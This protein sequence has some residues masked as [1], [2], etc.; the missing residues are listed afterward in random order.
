MASDF[1]KPDRVHTLFENEIRSKMWGLPTS[2]LFML[3]KKTVPV[4]YNMGIKTIGDLANSNMNIIIKRFGKFGKM[5]WEYANG[6]DE[7]PVNYIVEKSKSIGNSTT[8]PMDV[9]NLEKL[10]EVLFEL[11]EN[12]TYRLRKERLLAVTVSVQIRTNK[13]EDSSH[14][15]KLLSPTANTI[16]IYNKAKEL[17]NEFYKKGTY[18]R[19][20]GVRVDNLIDENEKQ[21]SFFDAQ[22]DIKHEKIDETLDKIK[23]K[24]GFTSVTRGRGINKQKD[25][26]LH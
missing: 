7:S 25:G 18:V 4:L 15:G 3:G 2:D 14:Q 8:L 17:L 9:T 13:F 1:E 22:K 16:D 11:T 6:I 5:M 26:T 21:I 10:Y 12:V 19:L 24:Y 23:D 20:I